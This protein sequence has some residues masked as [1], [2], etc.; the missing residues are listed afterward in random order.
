MHHNHVLLRGGTRGTH[1]VTQVLVFVNQDPSEK[2]GD[3]P[4]PPESEW[5][6]KHSSHGKNLSALQMDVKT[7]QE[8]K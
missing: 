4:G 2:S 8:N 7:F 3:Y 1:S 5:H 6:S